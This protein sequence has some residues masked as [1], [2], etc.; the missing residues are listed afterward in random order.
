LFS[1]SSC[2]GKKACLFLMISLTTFKASASLLIVPNNS[3]VQCSYWKLPDFSLMY[4][5]KYTSEFLQI[6][7]WA[8]EPLKTWNYSSCIT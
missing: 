1:S 7:M 3:H 2:Q 4:L 8:E 6:L 5:V